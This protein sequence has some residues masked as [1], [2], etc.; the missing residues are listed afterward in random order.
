MT[1][2]WL[3]EIPSLPEQGNVTGMG[4]VDV[5]CGALYDFDTPL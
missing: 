5:D 1:A 3:S 2:T 4:L